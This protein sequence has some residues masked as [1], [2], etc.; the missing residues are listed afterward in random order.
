[1]S[2]EVSHEV[3]ALAGAY[4]GL[5]G[6]SIK[7][8]DKNS[9]L[10]GFEVSIPVGCVKNQTLITIS[11]APSQVLP[12]NSDLNVSEIV[13]INCNSKLNTPVFVYYPIKV[14]ISQE[15]AYEA[16][17]YDELENT[18]EPLNI[19]AVDETFNRI[20]VVTTHFSYSVVQKS[21]DKIDSYPQ[22]H[23]TKFNY[24]RDR[25]HP[26]LDNT[27][28]T[29]P[30]CSAFAQFSLWYYF[31][32]LNNVDTDI[33]GLSCS[34][35]YSR[36]DNA[37]YEARYQ[38]QTSDAAIAEEA[39]AQNN[40]LWTPDKTIILNLL[41]TLYKKNKPESIVMG[42]LPEPNITW[43]NVVVYG[44]EKKG[45]DR[46]EFYCYDPNL[47][48]P[49]AII[50]EKKLLGW[51][52]KY[53]SI[54]N[55]YWFFAPMYLGEL[56][57]TEFYEIYNKYNREPYRWC[58]NSDNDFIYNDGDASGNQNDS[59]CNSII[60]NTPI[61]DSPS[62][63]SLCDDNCRNID[64]PDQADS[65]NDGIGD[66]CESPQ[67]TA[68]DI[69]PTGVT[70]G[71]PITA[72]YTVTDN[73]GLSRIELWRAPY[74]DTNCNETNQLGC[75][76][77]EVSRKDVSGTEYTGN[78]TDD[79]PDV[80]TWWYGIHVVDSD[81]NCTTERNVDCTDPNQSN[82]EPG[83]SP[84]KV[85]VTPDYT[86]MTQNYN[87]QD[88]FLAV[89]I[90]SS[91]FDHAEFV[92][93][94]YIVNTWDN[95][96]YL[97]QRP[98]ESD[99]YTIRFCYD[100]EC[101]EFFT[102]DVTYNVTAI[103]DNFATI[104]TPAD[105][106]VVNTKDFEISWNAASGTVKSYS[107]VINDSSENT[108]W[109]PSFEPT[110]TSTN[111]NSD[112]NAAP[113]QVGEQYTLYLHSYDEN[114]NQAT[115]IVSFRFE[116][117]APSHYFIHTELFYPDAVVLG[118]GCDESIDYVTVVGEFCDPNIKHYCG[119]GISVNLSGYTNIND[120]INKE[121]KFTIHYKDG[122]SSDQFFKVEHINDNFVNMV[123]PADGQVV[124]TTTPKL[125]WG[126][127]EGA[128][129]THIVVS[130]SS[131][132]IW[133]SP[134]FPFGTTSTEYNF[135]GTAS[136]LLEVGNEYGIQVNSYDVNW[137]QA[138]T[139]SSFSVLSCDLKNAKWINRKDET[140]SNNYPDGVGR[141]FELD[142]SGSCNTTGSGL[143][144]GW[145]I[146]G[147][148]F[149]MGAGDW[150]SGFNQS[151]TI[152]TTCTE[153]VGTGKVRYG[154]DYCFSMIPWVDTDKDGIG[155]YFDS[156][157]SDFNI[158]DK[159][160]D[161]IDD[162]CD[163]FVIDLGGTTWLYQTSSSCNDIY[164]GNGTLIFHADSHNFAL[165]SRGGPWDTKGN[166]LYM[167][168]TDGMGQYTYYEATVNQSL[169]EITD[170]TYTGYI[171]GCWRATRQ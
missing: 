113:L 134:D 138:T 104:I 56:V 161:N 2:L 85:V 89:N 8:D 66:A 28:I 99:E 18:W 140:C 101:T 38:L 52:L 157:P 29:Y 79:E 132:I 122:T 42:T 82:G 75:V 46:I 54:W 78:I 74:D 116:E 65:D 50:A 67:V 59:K 37:I 41:K 129:N 128:A 155:D 102:S 63:L 6:G 32:E 147:D 151:G 94:P 16:I 125:E 60:F 142:A 148:Q 21:N 68:F 86:V 124:N 108:V 26:N 144:C 167:K 136:A 62:G 119:G 110:L 88:Y 154:N 83:F 10:K 53:T 43:H 105:G 159:D 120:V 58:E 169:T 117:V 70:A 44:Y 80:G 115:T 71:N 150:Y 45:E 127:V 77:V 64:N 40:A 69:T 114:G 141:I 152:N 149:S 81:N 3:D 27:V 153:I 171:P 15:D 137:N 103:N 9:L 168:T 126:N 48:V 158:G 57:N 131:G 135:D 166:K 35:D 39:Y 17:Y 22:N 160:Y 72:T 14:D 20:V 143:P 25:T 76:G 112:G 19:F 36:Q 123:S 91:G 146:D 49:K 30:S 1:M 55:T 73:Q 164:S 87:G 133:W 98:Q 5:T 23:I 92:S 12:P 121:Y 130:D 34:W 145:S 96:A 156:C 139:W 97:S 13:S 118:M 162:S 7:V 51:D 4:V 33:Y 95:H 90:T 165:G 170:G 163:E 106:S 93:G 109:G 47:K 111:Y 107:M 11:N 31:N 100:S 84:I 24:T 61:L